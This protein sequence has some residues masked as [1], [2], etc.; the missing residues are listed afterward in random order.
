MWFIFALLTTISWGFAD[1]YYKKGN[2]EG[3]KYSH[4]KTVIMVG[5]VMGIH[6][7]LYMIINNMDFSPRYL[8]TYLPV[9]AMYIL[10]SASLSESILSV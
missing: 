1:L 5:L 8:L 3:D 4:L 6:G 10:P 7:F 2:K 9:S